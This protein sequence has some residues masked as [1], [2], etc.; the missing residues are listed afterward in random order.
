MKEYLLFNHYV[1]KASEAPRV[2]SALHC[3]E[4]C[5]VTAFQVIST[6]DRGNVYLRWYTSSLYRLS[7]DSSTLTAEHTNNLYNNNLH[8][9]FTDQQ[10][11]L[12]HRKQRLLRTQHQGRGA[13]CAAGGFSLDSRKTQ[14]NFHKSDRTQGKIQRTGEFLFKLHTDLWI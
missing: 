14:G 6:P 7:T 4:L 3:T 12:Q 9:R 2:G 5:P 10:T 11:E 1:T 8:L 13:A